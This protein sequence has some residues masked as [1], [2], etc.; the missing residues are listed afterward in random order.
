M[1]QTQLKIKANTDNI[2]RFLYD[3][4]VDGTNSYGDYHRYSFEMNGEEVGFF[5]TDNL[6]E[7]LKNFSKGD[8][9]NIRKEEYEPNKFGWNVIPQDGTTPKNSGVAPA[10]PKS[11]DRTADI[12]RQVCLKLAVQ[13]MGTPETLD[14]GVVKQRMDG[15]LNVLDGENLPF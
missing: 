1:E 7:K 4:P 6:N 5:A 15:L 11:D 14:Y 2:V 10:A 3:K 13:S 12:H 9:V 8:S